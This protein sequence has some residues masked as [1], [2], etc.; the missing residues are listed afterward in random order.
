VLIFP[1]EVLFSDCVLIEASVIPTDA[2]AVVGTDGVATAAV[3]ADVPLDMAERISASLRS[4]SANAR[5]LR[6]AATASVNPPAFVLDVVVVCEPTE[7]DH[8]GAV[9]LE[10]LLFVPVLANPSPVALLKIGNCSSNEEKQATNG[11]NGILYTRRIKKRSIN[12][13]TKIIYTCNN[14]QSIYTY[15]IGPGKKL[16]NSKAGLPS[17]ILPGAYSC[18]NLK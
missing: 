2:E 9:A 11:L 18:I 3:C 15:C 1:F 12:A 17:P 14:K 7:P 5:S 6:R 4:R 16:K 10:V 13:I 8:I